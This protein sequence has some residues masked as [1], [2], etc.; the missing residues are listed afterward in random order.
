MT[1]ADTPVAFAYAQHLVLDDVSWELYDHLIQELDG[2]QI[3]MT[4]D[5]GRLEIMS[6]LPKHERWGSWIGRLIELMCLERSLQV[7]CLGS[8]TFR[9][10]AK[11][12]GFEPDDCFYIQHA[13]RAMK[14]EEAFDPDID[15]P[16]DLSIEIDITSRS[17]DREPIFAAFGV[18]ELWRFD[19]TQLTVLHLSEEGKYV[20][21]NHS[22]AFPF[23]DISGFAGHVARKNQPDQVRTLNEFRAW[24]R[25]LPSKQ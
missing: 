9:N 18:Q 15:P 5:N 3:R 4:F 11:Q 19:G 8:T 2:R 16:P 1:I 21:Q 6:P 22:P 7:E 23:L 14:M 20:E 12:M 25:S 17:I 24:V 10:K 13:E